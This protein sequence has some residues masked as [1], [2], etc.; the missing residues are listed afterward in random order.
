[1]AKE[2]LIMIPM[3]LMVL[4]T[5]SQSTCLKNQRLRFLSANLRSQ[6]VCFILGSHLWS[7]EELTQ[8]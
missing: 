1:M 3:S 6:L 8:V 7:L 4:S 2:I 5:F